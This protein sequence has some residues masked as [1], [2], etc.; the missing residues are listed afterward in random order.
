[1]IFRKLVKLDL[2]TGSNYRVWLTEEE[3]ILLTR[4]KKKFIAWLALRQ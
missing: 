1:M 4:Y 3:H 2:A